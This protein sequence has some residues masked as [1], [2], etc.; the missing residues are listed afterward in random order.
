VTETRINL[1]FG[2]DT[3]ADLDLDLQKL[4]EVEVHVQV[5]VVANATRL[6][7]T[8]LAASVTA[9]PGGTTHVADLP[10]KLRG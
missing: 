2:S 4:V 1:G 6:P 3:G 5:Q 7:P 10:Y 9:S 8:S